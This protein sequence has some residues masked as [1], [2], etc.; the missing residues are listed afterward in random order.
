M[1]DTF[2]LDTIPITMAGSFSDTLTTSLGGDSVV[3]LNIVMLDTVHTIVADTVCAGDTLLGYF[4]SGSY[5][6]TLTA[7]NGC[8]SIR[9]L[10]LMVLDTALTTINA[11]LCFPDSLFGYDST[12][13]L[14]LTILD[15]ALTLASDTIC[16]GNSSNGY[17]T[18]GSFTDVYTG[19]NGCDSTRVLNLLVLDTHI[20]S[21]T[22]AICFGTSLDGYSTAGM[23]VDTLT[24]THGCDSVRTLNLSVLD[25]AL[26]NVFDTICNG[27]S[28]LGYS[29]TGMHTDVFN[30]ANGCDST[31]VLH[32][33]VLDTTVTPISATICD[34]ESFLGY[35]TTG[36]HTDV[37]TAANGCDSVRV[38]DLT[39]G[40]H[41][42]NS[43]SIQICEGDSVQVLGSFTSTAG[44]YTDSLTTSLG[45]DSVVQITVAVNPL[46]ADPTI[47]ANADVLEAT[48]GFAQYNWYYNG[49]LA[50]SQSS[51]TFDM[52]GDGN[53]YVIVSDANGC[54]A[55]SNTLTFVGIEST[56]A[57]PTFA[58][59]PNPNQGTFEVQLGAPSTETSMLLITD[60]SGA[61]VHQ[62]RIPAGTTR[63]QV[64]L[65]ELAT[66]VYAATLKTGNEVATVRLVVE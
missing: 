17:T 4:A 65:S 13:I 12:R 45:C 8:D 64:V 55:T 44:V 5:N 28:V 25:T 41:V 24:N 14:N 23:Y 63:Q 38:L 37:F 49:S 15:T 34:G 1:G 39:V 54:Q 58:V 11:T 32:L 43:S 21:I 56:D 6:D 22:A 27:Q 33:T 62:M 3:T 20:T 9:T 31:R 42:L 26:T 48:A 30:S 7:A 53:Y 2:W 40:Q 50:A 47:T 18:T 36:I 52:Q 46:P 61:V 35:T 51:N 10:N 16:E 29:T 66:G 19:A 60:V 57:A 59:F